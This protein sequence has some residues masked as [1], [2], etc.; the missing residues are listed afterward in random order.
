MET[1]R[2]A[3]RQLGHLG[4]DFGRDLQG[5]RVRG[6]IDGDAGGRLAVELEILGVGLRA[7]LD[8]GHVLELDQLAALVG[9]V[10][11]D[12]VGEL[13]RIV[14]PRLDVD[15]VLEL[16]VL[17]CG[18]HADLP[19]RDLLALLAD[20]A[21]NVVRS[22]AIGIELLRVHPDPHRVF[23]GTHHRDVAD[24][25]QPRQL[26]HQIDRRVIP[27]V[28]RVARSV[29]RIEGHEFEDR[30]GFGADRHP[31][32]L[33]RLRQLGERVGDAVLH[34]NLVHVRVGADL[35]RHRQR[36]G[37]VIG[38]GRLHVE[39]ALDAVDL[40]LDRQCHGVDD[41]LRAGARVAG[42]HLY[43]RRRHVRVLSDRQSENADRA[44]QNQHDRQHIGEDR[45][46]DEKL[47]DHCCAPGAAGAAAP[48]DPITAFMLVGCGVTLVPGVARH[49][50]PT[51]TRSTGFSPEVMTR[52]AP[53]SSPNCT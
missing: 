22:Q 12:D 2:E 10:L 9:L 26:V 34:Q 23:A 11:D 50:S 20:G 19:G 35:E 27:H 28:E 44:D 31:L 39:H 30:G 17:G 14:E 48:A 47:R 38:A 46:L 21:D 51:T 32:R 40:Q 16:L 24:P 6:L 43:R 29:R 49:S 4:R 13:F 45:V 42:R 53:T 37:A 25:R 33:H 15:G 5:I 52:S 3:A 41:G 18:R 36:V 8:A 7:Q 1:R